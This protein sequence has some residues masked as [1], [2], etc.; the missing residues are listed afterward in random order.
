MACTAMCDA[1]AIQC[2]ACFWNLLDSVGAWWCERAAPQHSTTDQNDNAAT[3]FLCSVW[4]CASGATDLVLPD[5]GGDGAAESS[6]SSTLQPAEDQSHWLSG[7]STFTCWTGFET[8]LVKHVRFGWLS[9]FDIYSIWTRFRPCLTW[10]EPSKETL[11]PATVAVETPAPLLETS[12]VAE[13]SVDPAAAV[14]RLVE[15]RIE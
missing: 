6:A 11:H 7:L 2:W 1:D 8:N 13:P 12:A 10:G 5:V 9:S 15:G 14:Q 4:T 3:K